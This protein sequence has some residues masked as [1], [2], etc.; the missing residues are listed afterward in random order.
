MTTNTNPDAIPLAAQALAQRD[1]L[2]YFERGNHAGIADLV[3]VAEAVVQAAREAGEGASDADLASDPIAVG[4]AARTLAVLD[5][6]EPLR[7]GPSHLSGHLDDARA[8]L[9][10]LAPTPAPTLAL[11]AA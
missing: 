7:S 10:A 4:A 5:G 6:D 1:G 3:L 11:A 9:A 2:Y 8:M